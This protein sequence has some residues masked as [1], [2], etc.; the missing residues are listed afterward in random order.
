MRFRKTFRRGF[1]RRKRTAKWIDSL[2]F[3]TLSG[4]TDRAAY[5]LTPVAGT[6]G[7]Q[8]FFQLVNNVNLAEHGGEGTV[9]SRVVGD[10]HIIGGRKNGVPTSGFVHLS[11]MQKE[12]NATTGLVEPQTMFEA[13]D[14][15]KDNVLYDTT[16]W[17]EALPAAVPAIQPWPV[18]VHLDVRVSRRV[19]N[20]YFPYLVIGSAGAPGGTLIDEVT[21]AGSLRILLKRPV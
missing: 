5:A 10:V 4:Q 15:G 11:I 19:D 6:N 13:L 14:S 8:V 18:S 16:L 7:A 1:V 12:S 21:L 2:T 3:T 17:C 9:L 20:E